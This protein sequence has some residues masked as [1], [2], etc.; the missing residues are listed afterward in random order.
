MTQ[1]RATRPVD[2]ATSSRDDAHHPLD[3][4]FG[5]YRRANGGVGV[6]NRVL[7]V[8]SV[9]C[10]HVVADRI[11]DAVEGAVS[12]PHDHG[13]A[14]IGHDHART[15]RTLL[16]LTRNPN[17]AGVTVVGL[18]CEHLQSGPFADRVRDSGVP[19][20]E[21]S[22]QD[23][24]G[25]D[26]CETEGARLTRELIE[27]ERPSADAKSTLGDLTVG[28]V[29]SDLA[30]S[31]TDVADPLVGETVNHLLAAGARVVVA[32]SERLVSHR[33]AAVGRAADEEVA[34]SIRD[35]V[36]RVS[37]RPGNVRRISRRAREL[38]FEATVGTW[39]D[40]DVAEFVPYGARVTVDRGLVVA[41]APSRFEEAATALAAAGA[42]VIVHVTAEG[43]PTGHPVVPVVKVTGDATTADVLATDVDLDAREATPEALLATLYRAA[44]GEPTA[45]ERHGLTQFAINRSGPSM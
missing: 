34:A 10:S 27:E 42:S 45:A 4:T 28:I 43:I 26:V 20:R 15:E 41:D 12:L 18:G 14:Q 39:G 3:A 37:D 16:S 44:D 2:D 25:S 21:L 11:A 1:Q 9:I 31:T 38:P 6:R 5:A 13:C 24:G 40:A 19:T 22:I 8:P 32:G 23:V 33:D 29:S 36:T 30:P 35:A 7:V 17:V